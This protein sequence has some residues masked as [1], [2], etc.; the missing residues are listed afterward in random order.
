EAA[1][2]RDPAL[3][4][5]A[6]PGERMGIHLLVRPAGGVRRPGFEG[7]YTPFEPHAFFR[8]RIE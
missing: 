2:R 3:G 4:V 5:G 8:F 7:A 6:E 1:V